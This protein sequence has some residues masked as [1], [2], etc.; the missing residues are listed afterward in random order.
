MPL[1][2]VTLAR[3]PRGAANLPEPYRLIR[4][5]CFALHVRCSHYRNLEYTYVEPA[6]EY[7][8]ACVSTSTGANALMSVSTLS[9]VPTNGSRHIR[10]SRPNMW[11]S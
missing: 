2:L 9:F 7:T 10:Q 4:R 3:T 1:S 11:Q 8:Y 5:R 6:L